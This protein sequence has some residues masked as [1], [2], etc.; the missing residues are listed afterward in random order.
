MLLVW[1]WIRIPNTD[2]DPGQPNQCG[3]MP[4]NP[5]PNLQHFRRVQLTLHQ[6][7]P[8]IRSIHY[9]TYWSSRSHIRILHPG[10][11]I[12]VFYT[13]KLLLSSQKYY[14]RSGRIFSIPDPGIR[15]QKALYVYL[16][17]PF[18]DQNPLHCLKGQCHKIFNFWF[19]SGIS[20]PQAPVCTLSRVVDLH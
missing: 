20:I 5:Y 7:S 4:C 6:C 14:L 15:G 2:S 10:S 16:R 9:G 18:P 3:S 8:N 17:I 1:I 13:Q 12:K 11:R 19:F